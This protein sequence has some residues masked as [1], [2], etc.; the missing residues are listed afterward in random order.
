[1][2]DTAN[3][4]EENGYVVLQDVLTKEQCDS[5]VEH[6]FQLHADGKLIQDD[7][8]PLSDAV[9]GDEKFDTLLQNVVEPLGKA[10]GKKLLPT[11]S[12][13]RIYRTGDVLKKHK[14][15]PAC[16]ISTTLTLGYDAKVNWPIHFSNDDGTVEKA[17]SMEPGEMA[18]YKGTEMV[19]WRRPFKGNWHCQVFLHY[20]DANGPYADQAM[21]GR[22]SL[23]IDKT[24]ETM[25]K[26]NEVQQP[27]PQEQE[28]NT[29]IIY[30]HNQAPLKEMLEKK[31]EMLIPDPVFGG[32]VL[33][34][35]DNT[36]PGYFPV[37]SETF[38]QMMFTEEECDRIIQIA[39]DS[40]AASASVG[41]DSKGT[42][43]RKIRS[44]E[45]YSVENIEENKWIF[46]KVAKAVSVANAVHFDYD[47]SHIEHSLQLIH[48]PSD[49]EVPGHYDW[50]VDAGNGAVATR[51]ISFT[52]QLSNSD[53]YTGCDLVVD[54]HGNKIQA[55]RERGSIS[56]FP[57]YMPHVVTPIKTGNRY[58]LVI[59]IHGPRRFK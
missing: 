42:V 30:K 47:I 12:Y 29:T 27:K 58:A 35:R 1:M 20:V 39:H 15:R 21:D 44:A 33:P 9:Y 45:I 11:Y 36:L 10:V 5:L 6:M 4:F 7:Q 52:A 22:T 37:N 59:W 13:A 3:Y 48:Y 46:D 40:Y 57:S 41:G 25:V 14:D 16:E 55:V 31:K 18:A 26:S 28:Q 19:H 53:S 2:T 8:C 23:G 51:K 34:G 43:A 49:A 38:P 24:S 32:V 17:V 54:D 56:L 50:H